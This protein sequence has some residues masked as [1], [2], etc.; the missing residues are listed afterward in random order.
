MQNQ[1]EMPDEAQKIGVFTEK[2]ADEHQ[3]LRKHKCPVCGRVVLEFH[4]DIVVFQCNGVRVQTD[5]NGREFKTR[6]KTKYYV[7]T[8]ID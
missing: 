4:K 3:E 7:K 6:C 2:I 5:R 1:T 8:K